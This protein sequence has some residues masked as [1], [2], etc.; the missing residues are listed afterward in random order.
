MTLDATTALTTV[1]DVTTELSITLTSPADDAKIA[2]I[3]TLIGVASVQ[4]EGFL[5]RPLGYDAEVDEEPRG[6]LR[7]RIRLTRTP[8]HEIEALVIHGDDIVDETTQWKLE[9]G[10]KTGLVYLRCAWPFTGQY[11]PGIGQEPGADSETEDATILSVTYSG[12]W[13]LPGQTP[14]SG[15]AALPADIRRAVTLAAAY[16]YQSRGVDRSIVSERL[17]SDSTTYSRTV[18]EDALA[19]WPA[20]ASAMVRRY[21]RIAQA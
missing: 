10:G 5:G 16:Q 6:Y 2:Y 8:I 14:V 18:D 9:N 20:E 4:V 3:E 13:I 17:M 1:A 15:V 21:K 7:P 12:G 11:V 19:G